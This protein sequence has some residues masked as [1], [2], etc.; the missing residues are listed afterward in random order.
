LSLLQKMTRSNLL[1]V[2]LGAA[3]TVWLYDALYEQHVAEHVVRRRPDE[4][5]PRVA[6]V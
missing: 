6:D 1:A 2:A 4:P 3:A 5:P